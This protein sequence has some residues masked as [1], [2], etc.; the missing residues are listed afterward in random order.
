MKNLVKSLILNLFL[1]LTSQ[2]ALAQSINELFIDGYSTNPDSSKTYSLTL[3]TPNKIDNFLKALEQ[4]FK[5][6]IINGNLYEYK[7]YNNNWSANQVTIRLNLNTA[8]NLDKSQDFHVFIYAI[9]NDNVD[10]LAP[11]TKS[12]ELIAQYFL[13]LFEKYVKYGKPELFDSSED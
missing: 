4:D 3:I 12:K 9:D 2:L 5:A 7:T 1:F 6:P 13:N 10:L 11:S 8:T